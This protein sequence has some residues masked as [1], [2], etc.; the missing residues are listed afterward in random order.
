[1]SAT[2]KA[3]RNAIAAVLMN[4]TNAG[5]SVFA[6]R[7]RKIPASALPAI[8]VY[9][10]QETAEVFNESPR[11][12]ERTLTVAIEVV[13]RADDD[14]DDVLDDIGAQIERIISEN[15]TPGGASDILY[16][17]A[18]I[19]LTDEGNNQHGGCVMTYDATYYTLD[20]SEGVEG[21][22]VPDANV[23]RPF[24]TAGVEWR[25]NGATADSPEA[26]DLTQLPQ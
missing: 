3:I 15:Q 12:L 1:M 21:P 26:K 20:V 23:L 17:G 7:T 5:G 6:S 9:T 2:R 13:A 19:T 18:E 4:N 11:E 16:T 10:R 25:P 14:L 22:G 24:E 8:L